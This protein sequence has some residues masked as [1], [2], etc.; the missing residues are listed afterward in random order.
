MVILRHRPRTE[1]G[2]PSVF[3]G[4]NIEIARH[5]LKAAS[6]PTKEEIS[7]ALD[8]MP[9]EA[10]R[11]LMTNGP[12]HWAVRGNRL[13]HRTS[14]VAESFNGWI[15]EARSLPVHAMMERI[16]VQIMLSRAERLKHIY[17]LRRHGKR[18]TEAAAKLQKSISLAREYIVSWFQSMHT[19]TKSERKEE[20]A[21]RY[22]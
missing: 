19:N 6:R 14:N 13:G 1:C 16:G 9:P 3:V 2:N 17:K 21:F 20:K 4:K 11:W 10:S 22:T 18:I 15:L 7:K 5:L 8:A 12:E